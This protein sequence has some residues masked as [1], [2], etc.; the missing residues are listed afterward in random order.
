LLLLNAYEPLLEK[1]ELTAKLLVPKN[2]TSFDTLD[3]NTLALTVP[4]IYNKFEADIQVKASD[5]LN[6]PLSFICK[7]V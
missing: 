3:D 1:L 2:P 5:P 6:D 7:L 4:L